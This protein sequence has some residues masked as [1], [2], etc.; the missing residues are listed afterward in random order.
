[1]HPPSR[2]AI[3]AVLVALAVVTSGG[4]ALY[5]LTPDRPNPWPSIGTW[6]IAFGPTFA[7]AFLSWL[8]GEQIQGRI[9]DVQQKLDGGLDERLR[10]AVRH[11]ADERN[12]DDGTAPGAQP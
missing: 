12:V 9:G 3:I 2:S 6:V 11:V 4:I 8:R 5:A 10:Q 1:M 7:F